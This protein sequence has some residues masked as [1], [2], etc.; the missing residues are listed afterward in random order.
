MT[1]SDVFK[2]RDNS[3]LVIIKSNRPIW[4]PNNQ[5]LILNQQ[6]SNTNSILPLTLSLIISIV[7]FIHKVHILNISSFFWLWEIVHNQTDIPDNDG[8]S[9]GSWDSLCVFWDEDCLGEGRFRSDTLCHT[10][11]VELEPSGCWFPMPETYTK[12]SS[13]NK[14]MFRIRIKLNIFMVVI[15]PLIHLTWDNQRRVLSSHFPITSSLKPIPQTDGLLRLSWFLLKV[16]WYFTD[17]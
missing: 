12:R 14:L 8:S 2:P 9:S 17:G 15:K 10:W 3:I 13:G 1:D 7:I 5:I 11:G 6:N 4:R 16:F